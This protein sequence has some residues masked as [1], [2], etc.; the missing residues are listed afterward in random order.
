MLDRIIWGNSIQR[1][2]ISAAIILSSLL[3]GRVF[4]AL[5]R[6]V[7]KRTKWKVATV[8]A[9]EVGGPVMLFV[10]FF[11]LRIAI[12]S[13]AMQ[14]N[15][16]ALLAKGTTF[17][18]GVIFTWLLVRA[19]DAVHKG[20]FEP[21]AKKPDAR[22]ELH[23]FVVLRTVVNVLLWTVGVASALNSIGFEVSAIL[24]GLGIGGVALALASQDTVSNFFGGLIVLT[25]RPFKIG[26]RIEVDGVNG[27]V[28]HLGLRTTIIKNWY[29]RE[30]SVPN[31]RFADSVVTNID[32]QG[33]YYQEMRLKLDPRTSADEIEQT[34]VILREIVRETEPLDKVSWEA[35]DII[36]HGYLEIEFWYA[37]S[38]W[39]PAERETWTNE[40]AKIS[41]AKTAVNLAVLR[42]LDA[43]GIRLALPMN[44]HWN[45]EVASSADGTGPHVA[46][47]RALVPP[48]RAL[49]PTA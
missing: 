21:Y 43:A 20:I 3:L 5:M 34:L 31:K 41:A 27:W 48:L 25:Q 13:L 12:E 16:R 46:P 7:A 45:V 37:V 14:E 47:P 49:P 32:S 2:A 33:C 17:S 28:S 4:S 8:I 6:S 22:I 35:F 30:V 9:E 1:W 10:L 38:K 36:G 29:G 40:Y 19:Y 23:L 24:A 26:E 11:G 15:A 18:V 39:K 42:R 44:V